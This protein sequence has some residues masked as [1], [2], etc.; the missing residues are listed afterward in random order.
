M[1][2]NKYLPNHIR[3][4]PDPLVPYNYH[5]VKEAMKLEKKARYELMN[6]SGR[7]VDKV[8]VWF[9][10]RILIDKYEPKVG[11]AI[12]KHRLNLENSWKKLNSTYKKLED[13]K[14]DIYVTLDGIIEDFGN[15]IQ[16]H[17]TA[18]LYMETNKNTLRDHQQKLN[19]PKTLNDI[20]IFETMKG[21]HKLMQNYSEA[22]TDYV[23]SKVKRRLLLKGYKNMTNIWSNTGEF[24]DAIGTYVE[25][26]QIMINMI[27]P[28]EELL[29]TIPQ[30][31]KGIVKLDEDKKILSDSLNKYRQASSRL[32]H[33]VT[34]RQKHALGS[35]LAQEVQKYANN[36]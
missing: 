4:E 29:T 7:L 31:V 22:M 28:I 11:A 25:G 8:K 21:N 26:M 32:M 9:L 12:R 14:K 24:N 20:E 17:E 1:A 10:K 2:Y 33:L 18:V 34:D 3:E 6:T 35:D 30:A 5:E 23:I 19:N 15:N 16:R 13:V 36:E 27:K